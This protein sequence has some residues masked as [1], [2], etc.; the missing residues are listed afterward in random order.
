MQWTLLQE[1][2]FPVF[3]FTYFQKINGSLAHF[4]FFWFRDFV[5][6]CLSLFPSIL[7]KAY[8]VYGCLVDGLRVA[9]LLVLSGSQLAQRS[10]R[11]TDS[12]NQGLPKNYQWDNN[13]LYNA[14]L[15]SV[16]SCQI[17]QNRSEG[18]VCEVTRKSWRDMGNYTTWFVLV[19]NQPAVKQIW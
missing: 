4:V 7:D 19:S 3:C 8:H 18:W 5:W 16:L 12:I 10:Y 1:F 9:I 14:V 6:C 15:S 13:W 11:S 17:S 2:I